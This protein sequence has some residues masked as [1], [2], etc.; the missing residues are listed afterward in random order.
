MNELSSQIDNLK[1]HISFFKV[2]KEGSGKNNLILKNPGTGEI[3]VRSQAVMREEPKRQDDC[4]RLAS[5]VLVESDAAGVKGDIEN[6]D[7]DRC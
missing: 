7:L 4:S 2:N 1:E 6:E 5:A 3:L